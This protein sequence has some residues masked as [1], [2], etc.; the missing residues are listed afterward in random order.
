MVLLL[1]WVR[2]WCSTI[3]IVSETH[4]VISIFEESNNTQYTFL[5]LVRNNGYHADICIVNNRKKPA[6]HLY[7]CILTVWQKTVLC[8]QTCTASLCSVLIHN[9]SPDIYLGIYINAVM[10]SLVS[11]ILTMILSDEVLHRVYLIWPKN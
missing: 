3:F 4:V 1:W 10:Q 8:L 5:S 2:V 7:D 11:Y 6:L 9:T